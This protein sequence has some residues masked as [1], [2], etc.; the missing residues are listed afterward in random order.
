MMVNCLLVMLLL[1]KHSLSE[2]NS[3]QYCEKPLNIEWCWVVIT[4]AQN[5]GLLN[6]PDP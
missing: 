2:I 4:T 5:S 6:L 3:I 1:L